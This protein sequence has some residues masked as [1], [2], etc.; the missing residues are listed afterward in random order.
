MVPHHSRRHAGVV[1]CHCGMQ[2]ASRAAKDCQRLFEQF[3]K[4]WLKSIAPVELQNPIHIFGHGADDESLN[5]ILF[6]DCQQLF[7]QVSSYMPIPVRGLH[8]DV[9]D[10]QIQFLLRENSHLLIDPDSPV[11][12]ADD[13]AV[14]LG[15]EKVFLEAL[16]ICDE[17][18]AVAI[19]KDVG[20]TFFIPQV[21]ELENAFK[22]L[23]RTFAN[24]NLL[25]SLA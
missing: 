9:L 10:F 22:I 11:D 14:T 5:P 20:H 18:F 15:D 4:P 1:G 13:L 7:Y 23:L 17:L 2:V 3:Y 19:G 21:V 24:E 8:I 12:V 25:H 16:K 6:G